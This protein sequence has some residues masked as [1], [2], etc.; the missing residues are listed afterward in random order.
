MGTV[1]LTETQ[2]QLC[3][4]QQKE[5]PVLGAEPPFPPHPG[6]PSPQPSPR[7][8]DKELEPPTPPPYTRGYLELLPLEPSLPRGW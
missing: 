1:R 7:V 4:V 8:G 6:A 2:E 5:E 3:N